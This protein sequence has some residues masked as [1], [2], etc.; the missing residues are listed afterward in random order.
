M[1]RLLNLAVL[2]SGT[3]R[4]L[5]NLQQAILAGRVDARIRIV[6]SSKAQA[7][8]LERAREYGLE[9]VAV[10]RRSFP[11]E[12]AFNQAI[13]TILE[14]YS[15]D[16]VVLAGFLSLYHPLPALRGRVMNVHPALL[17]AFGGKGMYGE[18][19]HKAV[20][21]AGVKISGCTVHFADAQYDH[22]PIIAQSAVPVLEDDTVE[23][24]AARVF[25]AECVLYP[26]AI[27]WFA[28]GRLQVEGQRVRIL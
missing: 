1:T 15:L 24:L 13:N 7:Y 28:E 8:G 12:M 21:A 16:L 18:H 22:G 9:A 17:P 3:G 19:V 2:L 23:T 10:P 27:Q 5:V 14:R 25:A 20:L 4:T 6:I 11:D 26:Q